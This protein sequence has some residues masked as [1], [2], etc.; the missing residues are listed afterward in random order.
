MRKNERNNFPA[1]HTH[2]LHTLCAKGSQTL[3]VQNI[4]GGNDLLSEAEGSEGKN[5]EGLTH[6]LTARET[7]VQT[8]F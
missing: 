2:Q 5:S 4:E 8:L 1:P 6:C 7:D 3:E